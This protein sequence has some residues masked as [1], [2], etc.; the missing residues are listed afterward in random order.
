MRFTPIM[1]QYNDFRMFYFICE[2]QPVFLSDRFLSIYQVGYSVGLL[3]CTT[4]S[5]P[6]PL[7]V[8]TPPPSLTVGRAIIR[9]RSLQDS[10]MQA[11]TVNLERHEVRESSQVL[12]HPQREVGRLQKQCHTTK[13][14][15]AATKKNEKRDYMPHQQKSGGQNTPRKGISAST[16]SKPCD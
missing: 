3:Y 10:R 4:G 6:P 14:F 2:S 9:L 7:T 12:R 5:A 15:G 8:S 13:K 11:L 16:S 1:F